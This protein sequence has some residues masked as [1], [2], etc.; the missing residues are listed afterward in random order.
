MKYLKSHFW[1]NKS[2][3]NGIFF[4]LL[5]IIVLQVVYAFADFSTDDNLM[6]D[7]KELRSFQVQIDSLKRI[8]IAKRIPKKYPFN[9]NYITDYKGLQLGMSLQEIDRLHAFRKTK[10]FVNSAKEFQ[11][12][13]KVSD[14]VLDKI[15]PYFKF[16]AWVTKQHKTIKVK[17]VAT[18]IDVNKATPQDL[19]SISGI[20]EVLSERIIQYRKRLKGFAFKSQLYEVWKLDKE[21]A[22]QILLKFK[23]INKPVLEKVNVNT[24][25]FKGVLSNPYINYDLCK[26]I[27][28][29]RDE[30]AELQSIEELKKI[31]GFPLDKYERIILYLEAK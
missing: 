20:G 12:V 26:K 17:Y 28:E 10:K 29:Y 6:I 1:Y 8:E 25:T 7:T 3:R 4:L 14:M 27:F 18:T 5:L 22:N 19:Q 21:L 9:P 11:R 2:Q 31:A 23:I 24:A 30:V 15:S 16:P 13:T